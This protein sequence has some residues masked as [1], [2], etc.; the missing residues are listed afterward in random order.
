VK[1]VDGSEGLN[2]TAGWDAS[3]YTRGVLWLC[4]L[5]APHKSLSGLELVLSDLAPAAPSTASTPSSSLRLR[6]RFLLVNPGGLLA[7]FGD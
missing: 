2:E 4:N 1:R 5:G 6:S 3:L 7:G